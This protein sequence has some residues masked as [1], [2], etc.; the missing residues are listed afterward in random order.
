MRLLQTELIRF[1]SRRMTWGILA[2]S[3]A[4]SV[5]GVIIAFTQTS[6]DEPAVSQGQLD[7]I[8][9]DRDRCVDEVLRSADPS[10]RTG[11]PIPTGLDETEAAAYARTQYCDF[12]PYVEDQRF[13]ATLILDDRYGEV[14]DDWSE[15]R[16]S[17]ADDSFD[18]WVDSPGSGGGPEAGLREPWQGLDGILPVMS[19]A[20]LSISVVAGASFMGAEYR[21]GTVENLL[22]WEP[23]RTRVMLTKFAAGAASSFVLTAT[24][25]AVLA[26]LLLGLATVHGTTA[27]LDVRFWT[28][29]ASVIA[30]AGIAG[31][32]FF[33]MAMSIATIARTTAASIFAILGWFAVSN[34]ALAL[35]L[36]GL[37]RWELFRNAGAFISEGEVGRF[38][39][40]RGQTVEVASHGYL[41]AGLVLFVWAVAIGAIARCRFV[42]QMRDH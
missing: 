13:F 33:V 11:P 1:W 26:A 10:G 25:M 37:A 14:I 23:R 41:T 5:G 7:Q 6:A 22:L 42:T 28:D 34:I 35:L 20:F 38:V 12:T 39:T 24:V 31:A 9:R 2:I 36:R 16:S 8:D 17:P 3:L 32:L 15:Q 21:A 4:L 18:V 19:I 40:V 30:R 29:L 27:G